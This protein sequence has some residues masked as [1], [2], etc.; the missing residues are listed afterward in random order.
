V[1]S[2]QPAY[3]QAV[4]ADAPVWYWKLNELPGTLSA[5][6][7]GSNVGGTPATASIGA[8]VVMGAN[9]VVPSIPAD[10]AAHFSGLNNSPDIITIPTVPVLS[11]AN[12]QSIEFWC[13]NQQV[14][15][16]DVMPVALATI[17]AQAYFRYHADG[18]SYPAY[19]E[20]TRHDSLVAVPISGIH[21]FVTTRKT[22]GSYTFYV[23]GAQVAQVPAH[24]FGYDTAMY[25]GS[26]GVADALVWKGEI[27]HVSVYAKEL[28]AAQVLAHYNAGK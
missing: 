9:G 8:N 11:D 19:F 18:L 1:A 3:V 26:R 22:G 6:N 13:N 28:T 24:A 23:D 16:D 4:L 25:I 5:V 17:G 10:K 12:G 14:A 7:I 21:H 15:G 20:Q 2:G 27:G